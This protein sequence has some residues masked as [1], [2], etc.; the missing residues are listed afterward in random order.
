MAASL[1]VAHGPAAASGM[2]ADSIRAGPALRSSTGMPQALAPVEV[3]Q[4]LR[5]NGDASVTA[6]GCHQPGG[7]MPADSRD[8]AIPEFDRAA[9][10]MRGPTGSH[11]R[12]MAPMAVL[13]ATG[14]QRKAIAG[15]AQRRATGVRRLLAGPRPATRR[16]VVADL[17]RRDRTRPQARVILLRDR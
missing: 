8:P 10:A 2:E 7:P 15:M 11:R 16:R 14:L 9:A 12:I 13:G 3:D 1:P 6:T 17:P 4:P 5:D